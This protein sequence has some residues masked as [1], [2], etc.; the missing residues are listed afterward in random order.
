[1]GKD[2]PKKQEQE[3][4][5][6]ERAVVRLIEEGQKNQMSPDMLAG[7]LEKVGVQ[8]AHVMHKAVRPENEIHPHISAFS[9]PEGDIA[10]PKPAMKRDVYFNFHKEDPEQLTPAEIEAYNAIDDDCEARGG[11]YTI[12]IR[13][14]GRKR[15][16]LHMTVPVAHFDH[17]MNLPGSLLL[18]LHELKTGRGLEDIDGLIAEVM[19]LREENASLR[20]TPRTVTSTSMTP[21]PILG[22]GP[23][24]T[25]LEKALDSTAHAALAASR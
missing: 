2:E 18:L 7:I 19:R 13:G 11:Q 14:R 10:R 25:D 4:T 22:G 17:R 6:F 1:M 5:A 8:S 3:M 21:G 23:L 24:A 9:Y 20:G 12:E 16:E 15:E